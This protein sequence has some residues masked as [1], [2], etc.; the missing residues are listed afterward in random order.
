MLETPNISLLWTDSSN[1][2]LYVN[3]MFQH[4]ETWEN[5]DKFIPFYLSMMSALTSNDDST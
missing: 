2:K 3:I 1:T 4:H 5:K